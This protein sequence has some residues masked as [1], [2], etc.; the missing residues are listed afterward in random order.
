[1]ASA[2]CVRETKEGVSALSIHGR[3]PGGLRVTKVDLNS[4][5]V[6]RLL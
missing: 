6:S 1:V 4:A 3:P 2:E 5:I